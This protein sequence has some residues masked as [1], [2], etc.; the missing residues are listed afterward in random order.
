MIGRADRDDVRLL[1]LEQL[2]IVAVHRQL[3]VELGVEFGGMEH[4]DIAHGD[5]PPELRGPHGNAGTLRKGAA[6]AAD[7]D[8]GDRRLIASVA[9]GVLPAQP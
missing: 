1:A 5:H 8:R 6:A 4:V 7:A 3:V 2:A 9:D